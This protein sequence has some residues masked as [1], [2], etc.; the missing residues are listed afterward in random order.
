MAMADA[1]LRVVVV[2]EA[3]QECGF[4]ARADVGGNGGKRPIAGVGATV[5]MALRQ[6]AHRM[7]AAGVGRKKAQEAWEEE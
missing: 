6:L 2:V 7:V 5:P 1:E 3:N 4:L